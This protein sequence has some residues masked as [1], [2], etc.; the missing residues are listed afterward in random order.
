M[1]ALI[2][3]AACAGRTPSSAAKS[4]YRAVEKGDTETAISLISPQ[5][6]G[7][8]GVNKITAGLQEQ[9]LKIKEKGGISKIETKDETVVG[10]AAKLTVVL[11][12]GNGTVETEDLKLKK[13]EG[14]WK[15]EPE[16]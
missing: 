13:F 3:L 4:F 5:V 11:T 10:E 15:I 2:L 8:I 12:Y 14:K 7:M 16:K 1:L 6:I 9:G